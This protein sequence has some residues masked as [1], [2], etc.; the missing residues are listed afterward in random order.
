LIEESNQASDIVAADEKQQ[1]NDFEQ[2]VNPD[3]ELLINDELTK[4]GVSDNPEIVIEQQQ[5]DS[6]EIDQLQPQPQPTQE[7]TNNDVTIDNTTTIVATDAVLDLR[8]SDDC[9]VQV[10]DADNK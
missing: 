3:A 7:M 1:V 10:K 9:W 4:E 6:A 8:F 2:Q 5:A